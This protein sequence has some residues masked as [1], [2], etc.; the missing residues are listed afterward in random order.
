[1]LLIFEKFVKS[2]DYSYLIMDGSTSI[3][4]RQTIIKNFN[5]VYMILII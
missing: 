4:S 5:E 1:M 2:C 3:G